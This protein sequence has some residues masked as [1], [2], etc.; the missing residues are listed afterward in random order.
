MELYPDSLPGVLPKGRFLNWLAPERKKER[1]PSQEGRS[2]T[3]TRRRRKSD[4][5]KP[6]IATPFRELSL[7]WYQ[8]PRELARL[9]R[10]EV[11]NRV[12]E[13]SATMS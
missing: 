4:L 7:V 5:P 3:P 11:Q 9:I 10:G 6:L 1:W 8:S 2:T 12:W 13:V